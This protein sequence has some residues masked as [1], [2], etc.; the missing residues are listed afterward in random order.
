[1]SREPFP[2]EAAFQAAVIDLATRYRC[3]VF[4]DN[5][6]RRNVAGFPD[7]VIVGNK[8][9]LMRELKTNTG[10]M[11]AQQEVWIG[12]LARAGADV[13]VW[14]PTDWPGRIHDEIKA[15]A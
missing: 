15:V 11:R 10:R 14:R 1:M 9:V 6:S 3:L 12:R 8:G 5:D 4:H 7:L 13:A 2:S